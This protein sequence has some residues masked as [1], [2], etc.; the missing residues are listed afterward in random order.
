MTHLGV[1]FDL[2]GVLVTT[3]ELHFAAWKSIADELGI[4][5][6]REVNHQLRGV[7]RADSLRLILR[8]ADSHLSEQAQAEACQLKNDRFVASLATLDARA[9]LP[10]VL[11][12][13]DAL[14]A[15]SVRVAV[16]SSS[17]NARAIL[18]RTGL[19]DR[20][21][22]VVDG[23]DIRN[24]KPHP[25]VFLKAAQALQLQPQQ[26]IVVEDAD[27][28]VEAALAAGMAVLG[29]ASSGGL[30]SPGRAHLV[31]PTLTDATCDTLLGLLAHRR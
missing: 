19:G 4:P 13:L 21:A 5:F 26:C 20:F 17:R 8:A 30:S 2:D 24:S 23:N 18:H 10:G 22:V 14:E 29:I 1:I 28:G 25:E 16:G 9:I 27:S 11:P 6:S 15:R 7:S 3:D 12:M 31:V